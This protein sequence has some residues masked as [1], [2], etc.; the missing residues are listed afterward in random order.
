MGAG[1]SASG[2][3]AGGFHD[4]FEVFREVF[5]G[6]ID[7]E[8][9]LGG[10]FGE[11]GRRRRELRGSDLRY[12]M[13]IDF[14]EAAFGGEKEIVIRKLVSCSEC[15]GS[16][17]Q[18]GSGQSTCAM[19]R[20]RGHVTGGAGFFQMIQTCPRC[21]GTGQVIDKP[22]R[23]CRG[24]GRVEGTAT[25]NV[26]IPAGVD[27]GTR[28]RSARQGE[29]GPR[30]APAGDLYIVFHMRPDEIFQRHGTDILV[31]EPISFATAAL[32]GEIEVPTLDGTARLRVPAGTQGGTIFRLRGKGM[33]DVHGRHD[34]GD[35]LVRVVVE[36][37]QKLTTEQRKKLQ[38]FAASCGNDAHPIGKSFWDKFK[39]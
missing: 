10:G 22:C 14:R 36:V 13:E 16:G 23:R 9:F 20:G 6:G 38:E 39:R 34:K 8:D 25:I 7:L 19:C 4:P 5:G 28:M 27:T 1:P 21:G 30:G 18:A 15:G 3:G 2:A 32:G 35:E 24:D 37:P 11:G 26:R 29:A 12:D 31:E 17:S 33:P